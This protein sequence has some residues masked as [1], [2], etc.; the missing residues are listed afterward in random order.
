MNTRL[1]LVALALMSCFLVAFASCASDESST[2]T[3]VASN[4]SAWNSKKGNCEN[5]L[6]NKNSNLNA[7]ISCTKTWETYRDVTNITLSE[8]SM[9]AVAFSRVSYLAPNDY[10]RAVADAA[11]ARICIPRHPINDNDEIIESQPE[12]L[13]C[14]AQ[15]SDISISGRGL[16]SNRLIDLRRQTSII[17]P[18]NADAV[19]SEK[20]RKEGDKYKKK[21]NYTNAISSYRKALQANPYNVRAKYNLAATYSLDMNEKSSLME[22]QDLYSWDDD[23]AE[24]SVS[25]AA[26]DDD[27]YNV[28]DNPNF[29][30]MTGY[31]RIVIMNGAKDFGKPKVAEWKEKLTK[32]NIAVSAMSSSTNAIIAPQIWYREGFDAYALRI[33]NV[34]GL[35]KNTPVQVN[36]DKKSDADILVVWGQPEAATVAKGQTAPVVQG[37]RAVGSGNKLD[38]LTNSVEETKTSISN[39]K[40]TGESLKS[41]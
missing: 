25:S 3:K 9:Y 6:R 28:R 29:K 2:S 22:L 5:I 33:R 41:F 24:D 18:S 11:L 21:G 39:A 16:G 37:K 36:R 27:F 23:D 17:E 19:N 4:D 1:R 10:D 26:T 35:P 14:N 20:L 32:N 30:L 40:D 15:V 38:E 34:L 31:M 8:R 12:S 13:D 7:V